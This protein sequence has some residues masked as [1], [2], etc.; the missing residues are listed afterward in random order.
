MNLTEDN[1]QLYSVSIPVD[2]LSIEA[3]LQYASGRERVY[4]ASNDG[5]LI[6]AGFGITAEITAWGEDRFEKVYQETCE[7]F[8]DAVISSLRVPPRLFGGFAF[9]QDFTP[10]NTWSIYAPADFILPHFQLTKFHNET[11]LSINVQ[12]DKSED[13]SETIAFLQTALEARLQEI[14][15]FRAH[16]LTTP[17]LT[18]IQFPMPYETWHDIIETATHQIQ[19]S[20]LDKVVLARVCELQF[21]NDVQ[22]ESA[23]SYLNEAY[24][25]CTRFLFEPRPNHAFYGATPEVLVQL[26]GVD[27]RTMALAGTIKRGETTAIDQQLAIQLMNDPKERNEHLL[28]VDAI[29]NRLYRFTSEVSIAEMQTMKL[30]SLQHLYTPIQAILDAGIHIFDIVRRL[31][32]TPAL[33]GT[34]R[35]DAMKVIQELEPVPRG[36]YAAPIGWVDPDLNGAFAVAIRSAVCQDRRVWLYA[37]AGI[38]AQSEPQREWDETQLKFTPMFK[39]HGVPV[40]QVN[41]PTQS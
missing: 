20:R 6:F 1:L 27:L 18:N 34:P 38:V 21:T 37:G 13:T 12:I 29:Q 4:W 7:L 17:N 41:V 28:V 36:W 5:S 9:R 31:H 3:F 22:I 14:Q 2:T 15:A 16:L 32:P 26:D 8:Q 23:I 33:G 25:D 11:W 40:E 10:D 35:E 19:S 30:R 39:A 24:A